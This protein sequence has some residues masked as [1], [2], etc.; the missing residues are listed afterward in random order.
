MDKIAI[1]SHNA[2]EDIVATKECSSSMGFS[3]T[4]VSKEN[5]TCQTEVP[6]VKSLDSWSPVGCEMLVSD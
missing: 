6:K 4:G 2:V 1:G 3:N 5:G